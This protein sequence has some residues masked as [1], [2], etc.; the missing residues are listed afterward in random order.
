VWLAGERVA[1][2]APLAALLIAAHVDRLSLSGPGEP[3]ILARVA[4]RRPTKMAI[5]LD[6]LPP[7]VYE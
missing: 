5:D 2:S 1:L 4:K 6:R 3:L 7:L